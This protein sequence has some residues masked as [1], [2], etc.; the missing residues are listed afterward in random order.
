LASI[1]ARRRFTLV[2]L[3]PDGS[4]IKIYI[5]DD[6]LY[7]QAKGEDG[8]PIFAQSSEEF[9]TRIDGF[10]LIF[11][12]NDNGLASRLVLRQKTADRVAIRLE[13]EDAAMAL[14]QS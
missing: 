12:R 14:S 6:Q 1:L 13:G 3:T 8:I 4:L 11:H 2:A 7:A 10:H 9:F 5:Q